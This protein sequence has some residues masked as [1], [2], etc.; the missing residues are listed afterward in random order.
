[1][2]RVHVRHACHQL[3]VVGSIWSS[4][5]H[6]LGKLRVQILLS[7]GWEHVLA[8]TVILLASCLRQKPNTCDGSY[9]D[10]RCLY[11]DT[12]VSSILY[13]VYALVWLTASPRFRR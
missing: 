13:E 1:M 4:R 7:Q 5:H 6:G 3:E 2:D 10:T 12:I 11:V 8:D 9:V